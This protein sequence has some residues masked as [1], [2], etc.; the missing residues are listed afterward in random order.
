MNGYIIFHSPIICL[1]ILAIIHLNNMNSVNLTS[2]LPHIGTTIFTV[3]SKLANDHNAINLSQGFPNFEASPELISLVTKHMRAGHN[4]YAPMTGV[5]V[6]REAIA[7][8]TYNLYGANYHP[9]TEITIT[10][11]AT[12]A[13][14][15]AITSIIRPG[16]EVI[17]FE[18]VYDSYVPAIE[19]NGGVPIYIK[20]TPPNYAINWEKV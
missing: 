6:L 7:S 8:K 16:D 18:P 20:L 2:K 9:D 13:L 17:A 3:M 15:A 1:L 5:Q 19:L 10:S 11:G 12:E 14:Y 4:Q